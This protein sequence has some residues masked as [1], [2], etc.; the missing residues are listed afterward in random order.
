MR[1]GIPFIRIT[2]SKGPRMRFISLLVLIS[3]WGCKTAEDTARP[4]N[5]I[6][7]I[8]SSTDTAL[9]DAPPPVETISTSNDT[10]GVGDFI[11]SIRA[12]LKIS[13][14][15][16]IR[17]HFAEGAREDGLFFGLWDEGGAFQNNPNFTNS[18]AQ[19]LNWSSQGGGLSIDTVAFHDGDGEWLFF[20]PGINGNL[21]LYAT[22]ASGD[23]DEELDEPD[24]CRILVRDTS[25]S[26][27]DAIEGNSLGKIDSRMVCRLEQAGGFE[28]E[29][30]SGL[31]GIKWMK[32]VTP[33]GRSGWVPGENLIDQ[34][35]LGLSLR[36]IHRENGW[37]IANFVLWNDGE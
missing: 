14:L 15:D 17:R 35:G 32:V 23:P 4:L 9:V 34:A 2:L 7:T 31:I 10:A 24:S 8:P 27:L 21:S 12:D 5:T 20:F 16:F 19:V 11:D 25:A 22:N 36:L 28:P 18:T 30:Y 6:D 3:I 26:L 37:K 1:V 33:D 13:R 29:G